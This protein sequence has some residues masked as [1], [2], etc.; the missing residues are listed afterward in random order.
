MS[1]ICWASHEAAFT[2]QPHRDG[3]WRTAAGESNGEEAQEGRTDS[4]SAPRKKKGRG[5]EQVQ[6]V[7]Q[8]QT[9][10][11]EHCRQE[12]RC[13]EAMGDNHQ[14]QMRSL[15]SLSQPELLCNVKQTQADGKS[16]NC[17]LEKASWSAACLEE[18]QLRVGEERKSCTYVQVDEVVLSVGCGYE[19][20]GLG[21]EKLA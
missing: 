6:R 5:A 17:H 1:C 12:N 10:A 7:L 20:E 18:L 21:A 16:L 4:S 19:P 3:G 2:F 9:L 11:Q 15:H 8:R 13:P 14:L